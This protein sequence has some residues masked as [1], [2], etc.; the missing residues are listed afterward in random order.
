M[1]GPLDVVSI[2]DDDELYRR[3]FAR[4]IKADGSISS[5]AYMDRRRKPDNSIS[6]DLA[7]FSTPQETQARDDRGFRVGVVRAGSAR[8][9][10]FTVRHDPMQGHY[11][12]SLI[13]GENTAEKC[14]GLARATTVVL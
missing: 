1:D 7:R 8:G 12:H 14:Y 10:D 6:V 13:E 11:A 5:A 9:L 3:L 2:E 4:Y